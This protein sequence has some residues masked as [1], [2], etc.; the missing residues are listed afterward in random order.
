MYEVPNTDAPDG[1]VVEVMQAG[2]MIGD[3][4]LR[5]A[6]VAVAKGGAKPAPKPEPGSADPTSDDTPGEA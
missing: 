6:M 1:T 2:Y 4:C 3:R 5:P